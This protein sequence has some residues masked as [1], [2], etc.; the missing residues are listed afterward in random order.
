MNVKTWWNEG[1]PLLREAWV[2]DDDYHLNWLGRLS[3][4]YHRLT[5]FVHPWWWKYMLKAP[6]SC[7]ASYWRG[8]WCRFRGHPNGEVYYNPGGFEPDHSCVD[9]GENLG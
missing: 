5:A 1:H 3:N 2:R 7:D 8:V 4:R 9:C 6:E